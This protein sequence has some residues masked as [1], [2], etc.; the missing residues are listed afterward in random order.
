MGEVIE[1]TALRSQYIATLIGTLRRTG[2]NEALMER[3][4]RLLG[5]YQLELPIS[6][7]Q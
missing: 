5:V 2:K 7:G 6:G 1:M 4:E 3:I